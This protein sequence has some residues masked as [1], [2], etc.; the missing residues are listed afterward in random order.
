MQE[1]KA[2]S[3][4]VVKR[5]TQCILPTNYP[6]ITFNEKGICNYCLAYRKANTRENGELELKK[7]LYC[8][9][10]KDTKY[11]CMVAFSGG[12]DS[13][14][15]LWYVVKVLNLRVLACFIDNGFVP[16]ETKA[17]VI[18]ITNMLNVDL[19]IKQHDFVKKC[20]RHT[21][22]S[23][24]RKPSLGMIG[25]MCAGCDFGAETAL[26]STAKEHGIKLIIGGGVE[27][28][29]SCAQKI[30]STNSHGKTTKLSLIVGFLSEMAVNP[31]YIMK[32]DCLTIY[33]KEYIYRF[34]PS[35][36]E[37]MMKKIKY[38]NPKYL[39][40]FQY[41]EWDEEKL[42][43]VLTDELKWIKSPYSKSTWRVDCKIA[44]L[45]NYL[46]RETLGFNKMD[47]LLSNMIRQNMITREEALERLRDEGPISPQFAIDFYHELGVNYSALNI[48]C[49]RLY[50]REHIRTP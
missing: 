40:A 41:I 2:G 20:I 24:M 38:P 36:R 17:N 42:L 5:C 50:R 16:G 19:V 49:E 18:N 37:I 21:I 4:L 13:S 22:S 30:L 25:V 45:K 14:Y 48:A 39:M 33:A 6:G 34:W 3:N 23:W 26:Y 28:E 47:E 15:V 35:L 29:K 12:R 8:Y 46:Y 43:R 9:I 44:I 1:V 27:L 11:D 7:E 31:S 10:N 32:P